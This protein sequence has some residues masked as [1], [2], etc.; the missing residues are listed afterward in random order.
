[1]EAVV[2][3]EDDPGGALSLAAN[4]KVYMQ[5][6]DIVTF[7]KCKKKTSS[8]LQ[9]RIT[10]LPRVGSLLLSGAVSPWIRRVPIAT[11]T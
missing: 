9:K 1:M 5:E 8:D 10:L 4:S 7:D 2:G 6:H 3:C 11:P